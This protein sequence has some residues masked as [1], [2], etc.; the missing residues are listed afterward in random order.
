MANYATNIF[1]AST[2][3]QNDLNKI[4]AF[5]DDN[6]SCYANKYGNSV[7]A[8]FPSQWEYPEKKWT[9][10]LPHWKQKIKSILKF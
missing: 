3:N 10:W 4:E 8:E 5:L 2:E 9:N 1:Y 6:F 7:D